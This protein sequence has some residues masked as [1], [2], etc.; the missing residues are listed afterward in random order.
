[1]PRH[2]ENG[3]HFL[4]EIA[5]VHVHG[6]EQNRQ[7]HDGETDPEVADERDLDAAF[8]REASDDEIRRRANER[9]VAAE[10]G[11]EREAPPDGVEIRDAHGAHVL[12]ERD[13]RRDEWDIVEHG[14]NDGREP[15]HEERRRR[16]IAARQLDGH[17][18]EIADDASLDEAADGD[19]KAD[20][21]ED[22]RPLDGLHRMLDEVRAAAREEQQQEAAA[23]RDERG[24]EPEHR[25]REESKHREC[26]HE[27]RFHEQAVI[28]DALPR[29]HGHDLGLEFRLRLEL[30]AIQRLHDEDDDE[31]V[32]ERD[33][34]EVFDEGHERELRR[35]AAD[36]DVWRVA[37]E[38]RRAA[39]VRRDDLR[40]EERHRRDAELL[41]DGEC[42]G[43]HE[44]DRRHV[45]EEAREHG[46]DEPE[47][48]EYLA[49]LGLCL[50][51]G[52]DSH[53]IKEAR[54]ARDADEHHHADEQAERVEIDV[55]QRRVHAQD[56]RV[57]H[58]ERAE[59]G[60]DRPVD[61]LR[62]DDDVHEDE[63]N[64]GQDFHNE[65]RLLQLVLSGLV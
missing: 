30:F 3:I 10:A 29:I 15:E 61:F 50:L 47:V 60:R 36:H 49:R 52:P 44:E 28:F 22:R 24:L 40:Q 17:R 6:R 65:K 62:D 33:G 2:Q 39:D 51:R 4:H 14:R 34:R 19:E 53:E 23:E 35:R 7:Q 21:E 13:H 37:D 26:K 59:H 57:Q 27:Q 12:D 63:D 25:V 16:D 18:R 46:R 9:A 55:M 5:H 31:E 32:E 45:V 56:A 58:D 38:R 42:H 64:T 11:A 41:R 54:V 8:G 43:H 48:D 20:E 1:M